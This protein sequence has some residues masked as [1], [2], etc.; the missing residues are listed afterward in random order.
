MSKLVRQLGV[1]GFFVACASLSLAQSATEQAAARFAPLLLNGETSLDAE[2][3]PALD[4]GAESTLEFAIAAAWQDDDD[5]LGFPAVVGR[6][7][8]YDGS[9]PAVFEEVTHFSVHLSDDRRS[10]GLFDGTR[11]ASVPFDFSDGGLHHVALVGA[12]GRTRVFVDRE[13]RGE[14]PFTVGEPEDQALHVGSS[15]GQ[16]ELFAGAIASLRI[17]RAALTEAQVAAIAGVFGLPDEAEAPLGALVAF[18]DFTGAEPQ[19]WVATEVA[20]AVAARSAKSEARKARKAER[21]LE[22]QVAQTEAARDRRTRRR[23]RLQERLARYEAGEQFLENTDV[24]GAPFPRQAIRVDGRTMSPEKHQRVM[25]RLRPRIARLNRQITD[26]REALGEGIA[27]ED[28]GAVP[29]LRG[30]LME[31]QAARRQ[32]EQEQAEAAAEPAVA[33]RPNR[34]RKAVRYFTQTPQVGATI[35]TDEG[36]ANVVKTL[37]AGAFAGAWLIRRQGQEQQEVLKQESLPDADRLA[38]HRERMAAL[39]QP[40][41]EQQ[42]GP[43]GRKGQRGLTAQQALVANLVRR[44]AELQREALG[45][46]TEGRVPPAALAGKNRIRMGYAGE[47]V[48]AVLGDPELLQQTQGRPELRE[49]IVRNLLRQALEVASGLAKRGI[50]HRDLHAGNMA[51]GPDGKLSVIDFGMAKRQR[52]RDVDLM[53][54]EGVGFGRE[55]G[56]MGSAAPEFLAALRRQGGPDRA[57]VSTPKADVYAIGDTFGSMLRAG[58]QLDFL[59]LAGDSPIRRLVDTRL[60]H[61]DPNQRLDAD[62]ALE[63]LNRT[64]D[65]LTPERRAAVQLQAEALIQAA[66]QKLITERLAPPAAAA[67]AQ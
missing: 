57:F 9:E 49:A 59:R 41:L 51:L 18:T 34:L 8:P 31:L 6:R 35:D 5:V 11:Y 7:E 28:G 36:P 65:G 56:D 25:D 44:E 16:S 62:Q 39:G 26:Y 53:L 29:G 40:D 2:S 13:L 45:R 67:V 33:V 3:S 23:D 4:F 20:D 55:Y 42:F 48:G 12:G 47:N 54:D 19:L 22:R 32:R 64:D 27:Y 52:E 17:W 1:V 24:L 58:A 61:R 60:M 15:D 37:G 38:V 50:V 14:I 21:K 46:E 43:A 66:A 10:I 30:R 63:E